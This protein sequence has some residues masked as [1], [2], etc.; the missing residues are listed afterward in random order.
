MGVW[1]WLGC[2][3]GVVERTVVELRRM[4]GCVCMCV[5]VGLGVDGVMFTVVGICC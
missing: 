5:D 4:V 1:V 3:I 2:V